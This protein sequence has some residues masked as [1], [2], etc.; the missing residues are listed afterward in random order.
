MVLDGPRVKCVNSASSDDLPHA[1]IRE[2]LLLRHLAADGNPWDVAR[3]LIVDLGKT[4]VAVG[5]CNGPTLHLLKHVTGILRALFTDTH[6][7][8]GNPFGHRIV[9]D[10]YEAFLQCLDGNAANVEYF[11]ARVRTLWM[12]PLAVAVERVHP[13]LL[14]VKMTLFTEPKF[15]ASLL[16]NIRKGN[17]T[18]AL[19]ALHIIV[20]LGDFFQNF[21]KLCREFRN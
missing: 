20:L 2:A 16:D 17:G 14:A 3:C 5:P 21:V 8:L 18:T 1:R 15:F 10:C 12:H 19:V 11:D 13:D 6:R 9:L 7:E 4:V